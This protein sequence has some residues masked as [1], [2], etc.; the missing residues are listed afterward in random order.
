MI[1]ERPGQ[2]TIDIAAPVKRLVVAAPRHWSRNVLLWNLAADP[3][4]DPHT[5]NGGC[6]MCQGAV[7]LDGDAVTRNV[8]YYTIAHVSRF[9]PPGSV[10]IASTDP[11]DRAL[12]LAEDEERAG[13]MRVGVSDA[14]GV[15]RTSPSC[16]RRPDRPRRR[17]R[18]ASR[19][20]GDV[21]HEGRF[22]T[23]TLDAGSVATL[24]W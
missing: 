8:A 12:L 15:R 19:S 18:R 1:V 13:A 9:V 7:T 16:A 4:N 3:N 14:A 24:V 10:R 2:P 23:V 6:S 17:Q 22:A 20:R 5:D 21:Q 11:G